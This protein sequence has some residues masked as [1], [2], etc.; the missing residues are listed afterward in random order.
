MS[1]FHIPP[2][3]VRGPSAD[4]LPLA[5]EANWGVQT[6]DFEPLRVAGDGGRGIKVGGIDT[7]VDRTH[8]LL[9]NLKD[10][11]D[12]TGSRYGAADRNEHGTHISGTIGAT[13]PRIGFANN[14]DLYHGKGLGDSGGGTGRM[15]TAAMQWCVEQGCVILSMSL[16]SSGEDPEITGLMRELAQQGVWIF[17]AAGN[18]GA[19]TP[20]V[21]WPGRS[22]HCISVA[23]LNRDLSPA[24]FTSSGAKI[25]TAWSG[26]DIWST[27]PGGGVQRMSG[28]SM[29]TP[30]A[31]GAAA[32]YRA[33]LLANNLP[34]PKI[35]EL[36][37]LLRT[38]AVDV[39]APGVDRRTGPGFLS[40]LLL[41]LN[42]VPDPKPLRK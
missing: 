27:K 14:C 3:L 40:P 29:A 28:T 35:D 26:V 1:D 2:D 4:F 32:C 16:G 30:G 37:A 31:A 9:T 6:F 34:V 39:G 13:D 5:G 19:G 23:A 20:D 25:D 42:L 17:A 21:D 7:G 33:A 10:A 18:S 11:K 22:P 12:F 36:R 15:I 8:P 38:D 24:S 41:T